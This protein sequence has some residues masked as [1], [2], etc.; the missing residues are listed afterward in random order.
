VRNNIKV[1]LE[2][3]AVFIDDLGA[4]KQSEWSQEMFYLVINESYENCKPLFISTNL[5]IEQLENQYGERIVSR[6]AE[7]CEFY[8]I[9]GE[10]KRTK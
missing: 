5:T 1:I 4:E 6:L 10:D 9:I 2:K 7:M 3:D 8:E